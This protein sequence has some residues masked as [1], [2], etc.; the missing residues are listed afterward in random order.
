MHRRNRPPIIESPPS[1]DLSKSESSKKKHWSTNT[2]RAGRLALFFLSAAIVLLATKRRPVV[3]SVRKGSKSTYRQERFNGNEIRQELASGVTLIMGLSRPGGYKDVLSMG[4]HKVAIIFPPECENPRALI[5][6]IGDALV[7]V[8]L[9]PTDQFEWSGTFSF[10]VEGTYRLDCRWQGCDASATWSSFQSPLNLTVTGSRRSSSLSRKS[11]PLFGEGVWLSS[12]KFKIEGSSPSPYIW[13]DPK[14]TPETATLIKVTNS[15]GTSLISKEGS[16]I[17]DKF[18][19]LSNYELVCWVGSNSAASIHKAF[20]SIRPALFRNQRLF[21]FHYYNVTS[22]KDPDK[23]WDESTKKRFRKCKI[24]LVS[25]DQLDSPVTQAQYKSQITTF[26]GH[27]LKAII[28]ETFPI[29]IV[30]VNEPP[31]MAS[32]MCNSPAAWSGNH[33]CND[34]LFALFAESTFPSRVNLMDVTDLINPQFGEN[35]WDSVAVIAMRV[36]TVVGYQVAEWRQAEQIGTNIGL[37][38]D[39]RLLPNPPEIPYDWS[40]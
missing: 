7:S 2:W 6:V 24:I 40:T 21:K 28:D 36:F 20:L 8:P 11:E 5:R 4:P 38:R 27:L 32:S 39:G 12:M 26:V 15:Q 33:P 1:A 30:T 34:A 19:A 25:V 37:L 35:Y 16:F 29:W 18:R 9:K 22:F 17:P 23:H 14:L 31:M 10:P 3:Q 13:H